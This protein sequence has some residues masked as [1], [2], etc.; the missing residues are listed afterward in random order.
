MESKKKVGLDTSESLLGISFES[1]YTLFIQFAHVACMDGKDNEAQEVLKSAMNANIFYHDPEKRISLRLHAI[2]AGLYCENY[3]AVSEHVRWFCND[4]PL[5]NDPLL[6]Y[7][8]TLGSSNQ[9]LLSFG[10]H[11]NFMY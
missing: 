10:I 11:F 9:G 6:L 4:Q 1:W 2:A 8:I 3:E 5:T 7:T